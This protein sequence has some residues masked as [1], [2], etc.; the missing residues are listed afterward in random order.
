MRKI[1][2]QIA[3]AFSERKTLRVA[4]TFTTEGRLYLHGNL[5]AETREDGIW[6]TLAGWNTPTTRERLG[7][8]LPGYGV[9]VRKG[10]AFYND[11]P[12]SND[13]WVKA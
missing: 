13:E 1:T 7:G 9:Y 8:V 12:I 3:R 6:F 10:Q 11:K 2:S 5:I 4:N